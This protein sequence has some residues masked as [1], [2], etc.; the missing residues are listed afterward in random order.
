VSGMT[1]LALLVCVAALGCTTT[2]SPTTAL[3]DEAHQASQQIDEGGTPTISM[4]VAQVIARADD[5]RTGQPGVLE[6]TTE[7]LSAGL[8]ASLEVDAGDKVLFTTPIL[9]LLDAAR[10]LAE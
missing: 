2:T 1:K 8:T 7:F 3:L 6:T 5:L 10:T 4:P 9:E